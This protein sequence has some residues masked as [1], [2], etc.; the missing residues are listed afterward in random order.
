MIFGQDWFNHTYAITIMYSFD[1]IMKKRY[2]LQTKS[3]GR[4]FLEHWNVYTTF[5]F[6]DI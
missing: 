3:Y 4:F 5:D 6:Y 2:T 1:D